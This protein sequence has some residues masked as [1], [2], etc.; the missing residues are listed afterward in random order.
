MGFIRDLFSSP[1]PP[2]PIDFGAIGRQ[3]QAAN[4]EAARVGAKLARP[5]VLTPYSTTTFR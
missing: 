3:Q 5:D 1:K 4:V 2:P